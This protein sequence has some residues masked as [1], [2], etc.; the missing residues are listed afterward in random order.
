M[1]SDESARLTVLL[2]KAADSIRFERHKVD[3]LEAENSSLKAEIGHL[4]SNMEKD[5]VTRLKELV[6]QNQLATQIIA[7]LRKENESLR[8][9]CSA[10]DRERMHE[11]QDISG[12]Q[13]SVC[14]SNLHHCTKH[15]RI[16]FDDEKR[17]PT[18]NSSNDCSD[19]TCSIAV[20]YHGDSPYETVGYGEMMT[21]R[22]RRAMTPIAT[23]EQ[24]KEKVH[25]MVH[26]LQIKMRNE[27]MLFH[28]TRVDNC[29]YQIGKRKIH[30]SVDSGK[31]M[32]KCGGGHVDFIE[33]IRRN[34]LCECL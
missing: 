23:K 7:A 21:N 12:K 6:V 29:V 25:R 33:Y 10:G 14:V 30:L 11:E 16:R 17:H 2:A 32:V 3:Q 9:L 34:K 18:R 28:I 15:N 13:F 22:L 24:L 5:T 27:G 20:E 1:P 31:L 19:P 26:E 8:V 4:S